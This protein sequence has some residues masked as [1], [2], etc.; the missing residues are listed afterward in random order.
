[1]SLRLES[2]RLLTWRAAALKD[3]NKSYTKEAAMAKLS[4]SETSTFCAHQA[5]KF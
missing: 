2:S 3:N 4:S 1:M 5:C